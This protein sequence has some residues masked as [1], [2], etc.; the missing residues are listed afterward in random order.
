MTRPGSRAV[1]IGVGNEFRRDDGVGPHVVARLRDRV[2]PGVDLVI[3][4]GE[5]AELLEAW[6]G[7]GLAVVVD[8]VRAVPSVPG[9]LH[10]VVLAAT[11]ALPG[12]AVSSHGLGV[13]AA[14]A[15]AA[16]LGRLP[17]CLIVHAVE[18]ADTTQGLGLTP[19][20]AAAADALADAVL[21]E[22]TSP[23][24]SAAG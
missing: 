16:A 15:L 12:T 22:L 8:A 21:R 2:P 10:R 3:S 19:E 1:V 14:A 13:E 7:A 24:V 6:E 11:T 9:R 23:W 18:V 5:P 20:V 4:D 17:A